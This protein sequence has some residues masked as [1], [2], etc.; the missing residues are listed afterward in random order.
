MSPKDALYIWY[1]TPGKVGRCVL[2]RD[3]RPFPLSF[4]STLP[5]FS[6]LEK[7]APSSAVHRLCDLCVAGPK[8][9]EQSD[10]KLNSET[11]SQ[12]KSLGEG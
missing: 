10:Y 5:Q 2:E 4:L 12:T 8:A 1:H 11:P 9:M 6:F 7:W 3:A